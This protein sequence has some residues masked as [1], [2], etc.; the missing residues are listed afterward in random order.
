MLYADTGAIS[1]LYTCGNNVHR[2]AGHYLPI[3]KCGKLLC[4]FIK[5]TLQV[6]IFHTILHSEM[7]IPLELL[8][9]RQPGMM[10][11][12]QV[13]FPDNTLVTKPPI[14]LIDVQQYKF[15]FL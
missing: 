7:I 14:E 3:R 5:A 8:V 15:T 1:T 13:Y 9:T 4:D 2:A 12:Y 10:I 6:R 11:L